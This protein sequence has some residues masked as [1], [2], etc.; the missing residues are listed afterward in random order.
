M[1]VLIGF[2]CIFVFVV[3]FCEKLRRGISDTQLR[4]KFGLLSFY[5]M[6]INHALDLG[7]L[8]AITFL[9]SKCTGVF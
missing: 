1:D 2:L 7:V 9:L 5:D 6:L 4:F 3:A 8:L